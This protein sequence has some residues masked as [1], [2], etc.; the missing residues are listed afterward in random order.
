MCVGG[1][2]GGILNLMAWADI[3]SG[4]ETDLFAA[5]LKQDASLSSRLQRKRQMF[6][7]SK[8]WVF[9]HNHRTVTTEKL[10]DAL[11]CVSPKRA[12]APVEYTL[13]QSSPCINRLRASLWVVG[14][15]MHAADHNP[16]GFFDSTSPAPSQKAFASIA[17]SCPWATGPKG[18]SPCQ[19]DPS[20]LL[21]KRVLKALGKKSFQRVMLFSTHPSRKWWHHI[22]QFSVVVECLMLSPWTSFDMGAEC[23]CEDCDVFI[24]RSAG[25]SQVPSE[26]FPSHPP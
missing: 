21:Q 26:G 15:L 25:K 2:L 14:R 1:I 8:A 4:S 3:C 19:G 22:S 10:I 18:A 6:L 23:S 24:P 20:L 5:G 12:A 17:L 7:K 13:D 9:G 16:K 11:K